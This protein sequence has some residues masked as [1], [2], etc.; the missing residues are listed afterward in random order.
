MQASVLPAFT[1]VQLFRNL[2]AETGLEI[3]LHSPRRTRQLNH[4]CFDQ[5][6][7]FPR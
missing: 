7:R 3:P 5:Q 2:A 1:N 4:R 6:I